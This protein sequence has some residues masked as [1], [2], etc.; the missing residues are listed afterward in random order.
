MIRILLV[1]LMFAVLPVTF[2][3]NKPKKKDLVPIQK[4]LNEDNYEDAA[5][6]IELLQRKYP[7][8]AYLHLLEGIC[9]VNIDYRTDDAI[10]PLTLAKEHYGLYSK[11]NDYA[12]EANFHLAQAYH[13]NSRF[14][15]ALSLLNQLADTVPDSRKKLH[16][17]FVEYSNYCKNAIELMKHPV[18]FRITNLGQAINSEYDEHSPVISGDESLLMFT[19]NRQGKGLKIDR[20]NLYPED[21]YTSKWR[22]GAW[23]PS[24][25]SGKEINSVNYDASCYLSSDGKTLILYRNEAAGDLFISHFKDNDWTTPE[26]LQ[27][28]ISTKYAETH[29]SLSLDG[30]TIVFTS[31]RPGGLGGSDIYLSRKLPDGTWGKAILLSANINTELNEE[32]PFL[33]YND[34]TLYF[35]SEGHT[36][37]GGYDIFKSTLD[38]NGQWTK[39]E[40]IGYPINTTG[41]DLFYIPTLDGQRVYF[42]SERSGGFGRSD[43]YIIEY[44]E[45]D[46]RSL[47]LVSGFLFTEE[48]MP[49]SNSIIN[50]TKKDSGQTIGQYKPQAG[51]G[52]YTMIL[53]TG[54]EYEMVIETPGK[55]S[56][57][58]V[59]NI[60]YKANYKS[61]ASATYLDP[62]II[63]DQTQ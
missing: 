62:L 20:N 37:M 46:E 61:R 38:E 22:E 19:S 29:G 39:A 30:N 57:T 10:R 14:E 41:D 11:R 12:V 3:K 59:F 52:K 60:P 27:K 49:S 24:V 23:I 36:S 31:D 58:Q 50:I 32:S 51:S 8:N 56:L 40:N 33:S 9:L 2:A 13:L 21:I 53:A 18:D 7:D 16:A 17:Q 63:K 35:A 45:R 1:V 48:G 15:E 43:V 42:A 54:V 28:P 26:R 4:L 5:K 25:N 44:P 47:A 34:S 55:A 6:K